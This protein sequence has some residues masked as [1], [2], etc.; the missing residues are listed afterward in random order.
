MYQANSNRASKGSAK[1]S[2]SGFSLVEIM[3]AVCI[4]GVGLLAIASMQVGA[5]NAN[6]DT[7]DISE[8][9][10][11]AEHHMETLMA[12]P[13][14]FAIAS[15]NQNPVDLQ[16][17]NGDGAA[18]FLFPFPNANPIFD[19]A[20]IPGW[21]AGGNTPDHRRD[22]DSGKRIYTIYWNVATDDV[23][24]NTKTVHVMVTW[25]NSDIGRVYSIRRV[26]GRVL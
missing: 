5:V 3:V 1:K 13:Y 2:E 12:L 16:D 14:R 10:T 4:L 15:D 23:I 9:A 25:S 11:L 20:G 21:I 17:M 22:I 19:P 6:A 7:R 18:G 24:A 26:I 8:A